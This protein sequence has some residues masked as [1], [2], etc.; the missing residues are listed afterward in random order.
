MHNSINKNRLSN[1]KLPHLPHEWTMHIECFD[2]F[3][4]KNNTCNEVSIFCK[5]YDVNS[6]DCTDCYTGFKQE[7]GKCIRK[8]YN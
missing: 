4:L 2:R 3:Y 8:W 5:K 1:I 6:G 7:K